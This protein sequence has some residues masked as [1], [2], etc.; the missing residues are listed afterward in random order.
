MRALARDAGKRS[1]VALLGS[2]KDRADSLAEGLRNLAWPEEAFGPAGR[3][4][5]RLDSS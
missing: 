1:A 5:I 3:R 2:L 4:Q